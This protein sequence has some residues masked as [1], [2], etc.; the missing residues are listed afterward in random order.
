MAYLEG[1]VSP[2]KNS[3]RTVGKK[4]A[5]LEPPSYQ[6]G[7]PHMVASA[8]LYGPDA[9][10]RHKRAREEAVMGSGEAKKK[11]RGP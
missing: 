7:R 8:V 1:H 6:P 10:A 9:G 4:T 2:A 3:R 5:D 11:H